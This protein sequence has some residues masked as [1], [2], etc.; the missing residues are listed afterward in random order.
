ML[1]AEKMKDVR[2]SSA[3]ILLFALL[4]SVDAVSSK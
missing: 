3:R 2:R 1:D 4:I